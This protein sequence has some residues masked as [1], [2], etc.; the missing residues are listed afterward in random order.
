MLKNYSA[1]QRRDHTKYFSLY[2]AQNGGDNIMLNNVRSGAN[3]DDAW[4]S[5]PSTD[6]WHPRA[7]NGYRDNEPVH[8]IPPQE[9][10][11]GYGVGIGGSIHQAPS[12]QASVDQA[13]LEHPSKANEAAI[14]P[15]H[16]RSMSQGGKSYDPSG[17]PPSYHGHDSEHGTL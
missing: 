13:Y 8:Q 7:D 10:G 3:G 1:D 9:K 4:D 11:T 2:E 15:A 5:R 16:A 17:A 6:S 14:P 12:K